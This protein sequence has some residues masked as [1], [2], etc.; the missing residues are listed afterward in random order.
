[1]QPYESYFSDFVHSPPDDLSVGDDIPAKNQSESNDKNS[2]SIIQRVL[3]DDNNDFSSHQ[4]SNSE[5]CNKEFV[6][7]ELFDLTIPVH[8]LQE[9]DSNSSIIEN[10]DVASLVSRKR[11]FVSILINTDSRFIK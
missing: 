1:M 6:V 7:P 10:V 2:L 4:S 5:K 8:I 11:P 3:P 9:G